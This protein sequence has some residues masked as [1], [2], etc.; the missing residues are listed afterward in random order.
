MLVAGIL[1]YITSI[2]MYKFIMKHPQIMDICD[3]GYVSRTQ[4]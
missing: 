2:T 3:F 1:F 4:L